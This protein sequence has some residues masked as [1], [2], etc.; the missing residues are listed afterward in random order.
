MIRLTRHD[1]VSSSQGAG[2]K[3]GVPSE[4]WRRPE[5]CDSFYPRKL[6]DAAE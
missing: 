6:P 3:Q 4:Q 2:A 1:T 5:L